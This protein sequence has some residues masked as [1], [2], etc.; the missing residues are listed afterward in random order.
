MN[1]LFKIITDNAANTDFKVL[2]QSLKIQNLELMMSIG[3]QDFEKSTKQRVVVNVDLEI[4]ENSKVQSDNIK[5]VICYAGIVK[6][7]EALSM[8]KHYSLVETF[9][10][11]IAATCLGSGEQAKKVM[12][13]VQKPDILDNANVGVTIILEK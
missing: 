11:D 6:A 2:K 10:Y 9:A 12:V 3:V 4:D 13:S 5:E 1:S 7:I 8:Q